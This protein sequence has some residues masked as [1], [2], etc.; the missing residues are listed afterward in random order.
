MKLFVIMI[1]LKVFSPAL[2]PVLCTI[3]EF[4]RALGSSLAY[5]LVDDKMKTDHYS[6]EV[7]AALEMCLN[8]VKTASNFFDRLLR[9]CGGVCNVEAKFETT[10]H[11][12]R[13]MLANEKLQRLN[14]K[15]DENQ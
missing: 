14:S 1:L 15:L 6:K 13:L 12:T 2:T 10:N 3:L 7:L 8:V 9:L 5:V 4:L 11:S